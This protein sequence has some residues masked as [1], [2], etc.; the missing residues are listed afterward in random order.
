MVRCG[1]CRLHDGAADL[2]ELLVEDR[3]TI[4]KCSFRRLCDPSE[5]RRC[6]TACSSGIG[7]VILHTRQSYWE[8]R[9]GPETSLKSIGRSRDISGLPEKIRSKFRMQGPDE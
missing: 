4:A 6:G 8:L 7:K 3:L 9:R 5:N 1:I 2:E